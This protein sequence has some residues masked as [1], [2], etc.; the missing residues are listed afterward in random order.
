MKAFY[1]LISI[2]LIV[3]CGG[4]DTPNNNDELEIAPP[5]ASG[6][7]LTQKLPIKDNRDIE[8]FE[9][10]MIGN[11]HSSSVSR[12][13]KLLFSYV[14]QREVEISTIFGAHLVDTVA[15]V[16]NIDR[17]NENSWSHVILQ[18]QK[19]SQSQSTLYSTEST[20]TW[21]KRVKTQGGTPILFPEHPQK[22]NRS[23]AEYVHRIHSKIA[24]QEPS[25]VAPVGLAWD[26]VLEIQPMLGLYSADGNHA[27]ELGGFLSA[28][29][30][31]EVTTG[32]S[33]DLIPYIEDLPGDEMTQDLFGLM[34]S[35]AIL[36]NPSCIY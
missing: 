11:S 33:A 28:L 22:G 31:Y 19:Y 25:C 13:L 35:K 8:K 4:S 9:I 17:F 14:E 2:F 5:L 3:G 34:A 24:F 15:K 26:F 16:E 20:K 32:L 21:I 29:V 6:G 12:S 23:E 10:L 18:G 7:Q 36:E 1:L 27:S 30:I